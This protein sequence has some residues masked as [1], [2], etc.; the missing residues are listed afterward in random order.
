ML[1]EFKVLLLLL[2]LFQLAF[3]TNGSDNYPGGGQGGDNYPGGSQGDDD[4]HGD[5]GHNQRRCKID[6]NPGYHEVTLR[7]GYDTLAK[8]DFMLS[9]LEFEGYCNCKLII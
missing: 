3:F 4:D 8:R 7:K 6:Y 1:K 9:D 2:C 5:D